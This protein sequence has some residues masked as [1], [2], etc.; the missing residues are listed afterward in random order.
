VLAAGP[1]FAGPVRKLHRGVLLTT[2]APA[3][4]LAT[5]P[6]SL[7]QRPENHQRR[8]AL[9]FF[10]QHGVRDRFEVIQ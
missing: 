4:R 5:H 8:K 7:G 6:S 1:A 9:Q 10:A 3:R 2:G